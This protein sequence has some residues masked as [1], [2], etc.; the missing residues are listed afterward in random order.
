MSWNLEEAISYYRNQGADKDQTVLISLLR[1]IQRENGCIPLYVLRSICDA[2]GI[3]EGIPMALIKRIPSLRLG[4][5]HCL[6]LCSGP[7]CGKHKAL[8]ASA[9]RLQKQAGFVLKYVP[10]MRMCG[11]GPNIRWDGELYHGATEALLQKLADD[12]QKK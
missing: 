2:Y 11:K 3:K 1:E 9:E 10:C 6:E 12:M 5:Q 4:D 7:N 8:A